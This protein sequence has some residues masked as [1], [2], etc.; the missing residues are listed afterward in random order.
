MDLIELAKGYYRAYETSDRAFVEN[1]LAPGFTFTSPFDD[2][3]G[4]EDY[5]RRCW[6]QTN[7]HKNFTFVTV[8]QEG[9]KVFVAY[10]AEMHIPNAVHPAARFRNA[11]LMC[12]EQGKLKSVEVFF[13]DPPRGLTRRE[14]AVESGA[15]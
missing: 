8:M 3:I 10:D 12:F 14:F 1:N 4:R 9:D 6:P 15:G 2:H 5:F 11:E 7:I 13:G